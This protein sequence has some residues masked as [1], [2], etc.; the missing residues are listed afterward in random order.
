MVKEEE[1]G[2]GESNTLR[3]HFLFFGLFPLFFFC[4]RMKTETCPRVIV[5]CVPLPRVIGEIVLVYAQQTDCEKILAWIDNLPN[6]TFVP[7]QYDP[8]YK[9]ALPHLV[10]DYSPD[11][12]RGLI[13]VKLSSLSFRLLHVSD[14][15]DA[16]RH[17]GHIESFTDCGCATAEYW[18]SE[19]LPKCYA[20]R[21]FVDCPGDSHY[22]SL[23]LA[24]ALEDW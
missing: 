4:V 16:A 12:A 10:F 13:F 5:Q 14:F 24:H 21:L 20:N 3:F 9:C 11:D 2:G 15:V 19:M 6:G 17:S 7:Q 8:G 22:L 18:T 1:A 23:A